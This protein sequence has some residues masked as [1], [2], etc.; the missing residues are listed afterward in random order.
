M[1]PVLNAERAARVSSD[2][3]R[4]V[5]WR[6]PV[7]GELLDKAYN[8]LPVSPV[9]LVSVV[10]APKAAHSNDDLALMLKPSP[11]LVESSGERLVAGL[12]DVE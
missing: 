9:L 4:V 12:A 6:V 11:M 7:D 8:L 3:F 2:G 1:S 10:F 5:R